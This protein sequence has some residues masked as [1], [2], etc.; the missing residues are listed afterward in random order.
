MDEGTGRANWER[1]ALA[2]GSV[3][4]ISIISGPGTL[5]TGGLYRVYVEGQT[6]G[7]LGFR[8]PATIYLVSQ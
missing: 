4:Q 1:R 2:G 7:G 5:V 8:Y 3:S 6:Q